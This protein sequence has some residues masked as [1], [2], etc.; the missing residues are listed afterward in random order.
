MGGSRKW[1]GGTFSGAHALSLPQ[2]L[3][4]LGGK[5]GSGKC[6]LQPIFWIRKQRHKVIRSPT[7]GD[8]IKE[9]QVPV[10]L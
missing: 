4:D 9:A 2:Q 10:S 7:R 3:Q 5:E 8:Q 6:H 1:D